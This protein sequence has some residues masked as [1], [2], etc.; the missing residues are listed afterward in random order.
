MEKWT[1]VTSKGRSKHLDCPL[2]AD[3]C[4]RIGPSHFFKRLKLLVSVL[5]CGYTECVKGHDWKVR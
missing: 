3:C 4:N 1:Y 2:V 5:S